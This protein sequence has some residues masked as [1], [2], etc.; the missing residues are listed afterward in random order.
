ME[1]KKQQ[2]QNERRR[3]AVTRG[4]Q[5]GELVSHI[6]V[7]VTDEPEDVKAESKET[8]SNQVPQR[9]Q[10]WD[11]EVVGIEVPAPH[12]VHHPV[13][14]VQENENLG[15]RKKRATSA[16]HPD[17]CNPSLR[18][19]SAGATPAGQAGLSPRAQPQPKEQSWWQVRTTLL[20]AALQAFNAGGIPKA[21][22]TAQRGTWRVSMGPWASKSPV[23]L[24][25]SAL[26]FFSFTCHH[27]I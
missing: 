12:P 24:T 4:G 27:Q 16:T 26:F 23:S 9:C 14:N 25:A 7:P 22:S 21:T 13:S 15:G 2:Q 1:E 3:R 20:S 18:G 6:G 5:Q 8:C 11:G 19:A 17:L 10:V